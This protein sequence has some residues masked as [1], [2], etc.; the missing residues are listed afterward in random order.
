MDKY[1]VLVATQGPLAG[2][3]YL[4]GRESDIPGRPVGGPLPSFLDNVPFSDRIGKF[5]LI[6]VKPRYVVYR[7]IIAPASLGTFNE[8]QQ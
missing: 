1:I 7:E 8:A 2:L 6:Q 5:S 4:A 3:R